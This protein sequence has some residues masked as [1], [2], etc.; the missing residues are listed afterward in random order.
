[1][2]KNQERAVRKVI[3]DNDYTTFPYKIGVDR[4]IGSC[5]DNDNPFLK[6]SLP[7]SNKNISVKSL[8]L[9]SNKNVLKNISFHQSCKCGC[10]LDEKVFKIIF[11]NLIKIN[12]DV[13]V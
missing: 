12:V 2:L 9:I 11:K 13:N 5:N 3:I 1:M 8:D 7:D 4:C 10:L 6:F